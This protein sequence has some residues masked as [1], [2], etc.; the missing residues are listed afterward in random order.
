MKI[1]LFLLLVAPLAQ[2]QTEDVFASSSQ[3]RSR[4]VRWPERLP[5]FIKEGIAQSRETGKPILLDFSAK[6]C[7]PCKHMERKVF[8]H[9]RVA[10]ELENWIF[11]KVD[12][13]K[14]PELARSFAV[15]A[16]PAYFL[17][18]SDHEILSKSVG[19]QIPFDFSDWLAFSRNRGS[20]S[21][22]VA[23]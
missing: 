7:G 18:S 1:F 16:L 3:D 12:R 22:M 11:I 10:S 17:L 9:P 4:V 19:L 14:H 2:A 6:W 21:M 20:G 13:D 23:D 15:T 8:P 5:E